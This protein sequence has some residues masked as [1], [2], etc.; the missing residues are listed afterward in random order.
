VEHST[1][2]N[3]FMLFLG[4][5]G[6]FIAIFGIFG[7]ISY[8]IMLTLGVS[9]SAPGPKEA[10]LP[11]LIGSA[12]YAVGLVMISFSVTL[13][14]AFEPW[15]AKSPR[16]LALDLGMRFLILP[17]TCLGIAAVIL[18]CRDKWELALL[19]GAVAALL[20]KAAM[21]IYRLMIANEEA[22]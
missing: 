12:A 8:T 22:P 17:A 19:C 9:E 2:K 6:A 15:L 10:A 21:M 4:V 18:A 7:A 13:Q 14:A 20:V 3:L 5:P 11:Y 1:R 16:Q